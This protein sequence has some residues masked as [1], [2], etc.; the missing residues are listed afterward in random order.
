VRRRIPLFEQ[1]Q[2]DPHLGPQVLLAGDHGDRVAP[3]D[4]QQLLVAAAEQ[5]L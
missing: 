2:Q 4:L 1:L 5:G 3:E